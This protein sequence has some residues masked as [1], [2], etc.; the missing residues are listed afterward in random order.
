MSI[1]VTRWDAGAADWRRRATSNRPQ[2]A[3]TKK[4]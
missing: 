4:L 2:S 1:W 3:P